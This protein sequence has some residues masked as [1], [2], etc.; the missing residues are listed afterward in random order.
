MPTTEFNDSLEALLRAFNHH[1]DLRR[2]GAG[3]AE[4]SASSQELFRARMRAHRA[5]REQGY[6][7]TR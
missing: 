5:L 2:C 1:A 6:L 4:L 3:I 7:S